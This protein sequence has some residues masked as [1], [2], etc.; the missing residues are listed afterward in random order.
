MEI[1]ET[2]RLM[3]VKKKEEI[4]GLT[5]QILE[6]AHDRQKILEIKKK[7]TTIISLLS[8]IA[9]YSDTKH[10]LNELTKAITVLFLEMDQEN[11][12][13]LWIASPITIEVACN[14]VN[15][16]RFDFTKKN[17]VIYIPKID[18]SIFRMK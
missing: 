4:C 6:M 7:F 12:G 18:F 16:V 17:G 11:L 8:Q 15:C 9:S 3:L 5:L 2:E 14:F 10:N 13:K 1:T